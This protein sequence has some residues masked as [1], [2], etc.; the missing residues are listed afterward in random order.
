LVFRLCATKLSPTFVFIGFL[1]NEDK[2]PKSAWKEHQFW[3]RTNCAA[4]ISGAIS[5]SSFIRIGPS[6][7]PNRRYHRVPQLW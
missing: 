5:P 1:E 2:I 7:C 3:F 6:T 4:G